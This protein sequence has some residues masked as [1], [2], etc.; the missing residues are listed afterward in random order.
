V[1]RNTAV[2]LYVFILPGNF[3]RLLQGI[4][5][6]TRLSTQLQRIIKYAALS[7]FTT[8]LV[9]IS[10]IYFSSLEPSLAQV[11]LVA[12]AI[13][14][15][16]SQ[17]PEITGRVVLSETAEGLRITGTIANASPGEHGF[18]IHEYGSC[19]NDGQDAGDHF[20]P[21]GVQHGHLLSHGYE[22]AH[23]GD[24]GNI[25]VSPDGTANWDQIYPGLTL[26]DSPYSVTG[27][28][29]ILHA[30]PDDFGQPSGNAGPR[31]ACGLIN[32]R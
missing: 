26:S 18:H 5:F 1:H 10:T 7:T 3:C 6:M 24:L 8:V 27:R 25:Y 31:I 21:V 2:N 11:P 17:S 29:F 12:E 16:T 20:N 4:L 13:I 32:I 28:S 30:Y 9:I 15:G 22:Y 23:A 19:A 14:S